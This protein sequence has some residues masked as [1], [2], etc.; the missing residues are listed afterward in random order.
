MALAESNFWIQTAPK[1]PTAKL[2]RLYSRTPY[3]FQGYWKSPEKTAAAFRG[4]YCTV[5]DM[6]RRD[7]DGYFHLADRKSN[8]IISGGLNVYPSEVEQVLGTHPKVKDVAAIGVPHE[9]WGE[10]VHAVIVLH[11]DQVASDSDILDWCRDKNS[12]IQ[13]AKIDL[14]HC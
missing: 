2:A 14:L 13:T 8:M 7:A 5:G 9:K 4:E 11:Q 6:A 10:A 1:S 3:A 12:R